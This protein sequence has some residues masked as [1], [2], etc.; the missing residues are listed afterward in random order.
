MS[1]KL[2]EFNPANAKD[3]GQLTDTTTAGLL[4]YGLREG[5]TDAEYHLALRLEA[6]RELTFKLINE[7]M[8][9]GFGAGMSELELIDVKVDLTNELLGLSTSKRFAKTA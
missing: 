2:T 4:E 8:A 1:I 9:E 6:M 7:R 3:A 5:C